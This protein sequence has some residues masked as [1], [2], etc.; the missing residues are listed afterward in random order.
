[1]VGRSFTIAYNDTKDRFV[2]YRS[3][4]PTTYINDG[5]YVLTA[6]PSDLN[7]LY[8]HDI[9]ER[10]VFYD[11]A[12]SESS[13]TITVN[14]MA[15]LTKIFDNTEFLTDVID[16]NGVEVTDETFDSVTSSN[17]YQTTGIRADIKRRL[18]NWRHAIT[19]EFGTRNRIRSH[20]MKQKF[21]IP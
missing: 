15:S 5:R 6:N 18:R 4:K 2:S 14:P 11:N 19:Y 17:S 13:I 3:F 10:G 9:G 8:L 21:S 1:M 16:T 12:P 20:W 7:D